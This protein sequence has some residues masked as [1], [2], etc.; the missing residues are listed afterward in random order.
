MS[1]VVCPKQK[2]PGEFL[3]CE[4][5]LPYSSWFR[6]NLNVADTISCSEQALVLRGRAEGGAA[7]VN[8]SSNDNLTNINLWGRRDSCIFL[9][10]KK[11]LSFLEKEKL[12]ESV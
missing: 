9:K 4:C 10:Q 2:S 3:G 11:P 8:T 5:L 12:L 6:T 7:V 1:Y